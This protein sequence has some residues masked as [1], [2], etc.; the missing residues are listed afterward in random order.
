MWSGYPIHHLIVHIRL[1]F[2]LFQSLYAEA[3]EY[4]L[5]GFVEIYITDRRTPYIIDQNRSVDF[6]VKFYFYIPQG[7]QTLRVALLAHNS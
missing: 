1:L 6:V 2:K 3:I 7:L 5:S 4:C